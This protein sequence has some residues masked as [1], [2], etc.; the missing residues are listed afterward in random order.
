MMAEC[1]RQVVFGKQQ[2]SRA[3][4]QG[5][6]RHGTTYRKIMN[7]MQKGL[8][9]VFSGAYGR[10][11]LGSR[12]WCG[13]R[14]LAPLTVISVSR[15]CSPSLG[16]SF[17]MLPSNCS[18]PT[19]ILPPS[20]KC[21]CSESMLWEA[22]WENGRKMGF[23]FRQTWYPNSGSTFWLTRPVTQ[24]FWALVTCIIEIIILTF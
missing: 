22:A 16:P 14:R 12:L 23:G 10:T 21:P 13:R 20:K 18:V 15:T 6:W 4:E 9:F 8:A 11:R 5:M 1:C 2:V 7:N 3:T 17:P 24:T 19:Y